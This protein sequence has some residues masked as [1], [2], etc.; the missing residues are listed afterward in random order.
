MSADQPDRVSRQGGQKAVVRRA[1]RDSPMRVTRRGDSYPAA[2]LL[3]GRECI[4]VNHPYVARERF[5][6][7]SCFESG[8]VFAKAEKTFAEG[9][10]ICI[11]S[12]L[13]GDDLGD[14]AFLFGGE[15]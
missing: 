11:C 4:S 10:E 9:L 3:P 2:R 15:S 1:R 6:W 5:T 12:C 14:I 8:N 13:L 7:C